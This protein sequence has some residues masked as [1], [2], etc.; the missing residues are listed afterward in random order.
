MKNKLLIKKTGICLITICT[1]C[2]LAS[3]T[4]ND[5][6]APTPNVPGVVNTPPPGGTTAVPPQDATVNWTKLSTLN[7]TITVLEVFGH[8]IY[9]GSNSNNLYISSDEGASWATLKVGNNTDMAI[10]AIKLFNNKLYVG[11]DNNGIFSSNDGG[12]T[13]TNYINNLVGYPVS[14]FAE[15]NN[16]LYA[17]AEDDGGVLVLNQA[18]NNWM[19]FNNNLPEIITSYD[20]FKIVSTGNT[21]AAAAGV[22]GTFYF[23]DF[24]AN[25]WVNSYTN[26][27]GIPVTQL[28][29]DKGSLFAYNTEG[30]I[31]RSENNGV[32]WYYDTLD[33]Q[34]T[35][36][37]RFYENGILYAGS[38]NDYILINQGVKG[39]WIQHRDR[40]APAGSTWAT[41]QEFLAQMHLNA[42]AEADNKLFLGTDNGIYFKVK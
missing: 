11:T 29:Y 12:K 42:I 14:S 7:D 5:K 4:K 10:T 30:K 31:I 24:N 21:L 1:V 16:N 32:S 38:I 33:L 25:Q 2:S 39:G 28:I 19:P 13:W 22:N 36:S 26:R 9:A 8:T 27:W 35:L 37:S 17:S 18:T 6:A 20:V 3:C 23:Y 40:T 15:L 34:T 41:G